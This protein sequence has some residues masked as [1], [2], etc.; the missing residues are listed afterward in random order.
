MRTATTV[1]P[2]VAAGIVWPYNAPSAEDYFAGIEHEN[3]LRTS[4][5]DWQSYRNGTL[6]DIRNRYD[7]RD[8]PMSKDD[9]RDALEEIERATPSTVNLSTQDPQAEGPA[10]ASVSTIVIPTSLK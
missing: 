8:N 6:G 3:D 9:M 2:T 5:N 10:V 4:L 1:D 7:D